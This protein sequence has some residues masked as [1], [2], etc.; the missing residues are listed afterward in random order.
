[1]GTFSAKEGCLTAVAVMT[2]LSPSFTRGTRVAMV[3]TLSPL[4]TW[5]S[6]PGSTR[7]RFTV[8]T[9]TN[10]HK[11]RPWKLGP[12][13]RRS[14]MLCPFFVNASGFHFTLPHPTQPLFKK[15][16]HKTIKPIGVGFVVL[17]CLFV[18]LFVCNFTSFSF[19]PPSLFT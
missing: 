1:M 19:Y 3:A 4:Y 2:P 16:Q 9:A 17:F 6:T 14:P 18:C 10:A 5:A 15:T 7:C 11:G 8:T 12:E 13:L